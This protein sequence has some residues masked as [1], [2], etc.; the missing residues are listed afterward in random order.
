MK[1]PALWGSCAPDEETGQAAP[2]HCPWGAWCPRPPPALSGPSLLPLRGRVWASSVLGLFLPSVASLGHFCPLPT[3]RV[4]IA[5]LK[6]F[7]R[8]SQVGNGGCSSCWAGLVSSPRGLPASQHCRQTVLPKTSRA[9]RWHPERPLWGQWRCLQAEEGPGGA[10]CRGGGTFG[11]RSLA[12]PL[13]GFCGASSPVRFWLSRS[14]GDEVSGAQG[15]PA[16]G[17]GGGGT[18]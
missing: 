15:S 18:C 3:P 1:V 12:V 9:L 6:A 5:H 14:G 2:W 10:P 8:Q 11:A 16:A 13:V 7:S 4:S 17:P